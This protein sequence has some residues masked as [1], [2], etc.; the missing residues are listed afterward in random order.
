MT[1]ESTSGIRRV[2]L[3]DIG[4][5]HTTIG[6][7]IATRR[8]AATLKETWRIKTDTEMTPD[9]LA[10]QLQTLLSFADSEITEIDDIMFSSVVPVVSRCWQMM[11]RDYLGKSAIDA[12]DNAKNMVAFKYPNPEEVGTDRLINAIAAFSR[13]KRASIV[14]DLGTATTFDCISETG[15]YL[16]GAIAPGILSCMNALSSSTAKLPSVGF[17]EQP[18]QVLGKDTVTAIQ[19]GILHGF[20]AMVDGLVKRL[21]REFSDGAEVLGTG[22]LAPLLQPYTS[23][24]RKVVK[25]LS[26]EGLILVYQTLSRQ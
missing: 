2:L 13:T 8:T 25:D 18:P 22:G 6:L 12:H 4:N 10:I 19:S 26:L 15:E 5:T 11:C 3:T 17:P 7:A 1:R 24:M 20:G 16:G 23:S 21:R 9:Q 14:V